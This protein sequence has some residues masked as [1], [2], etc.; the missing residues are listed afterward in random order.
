MSIWIK[1][2][3]FVRERLIKT[4]ACEGQT[5]SYKKAADILGINRHYVESWFRPKD[6]KS[7]NSDHLKLIAQKLG[8]SASWLLTGEGEPESQTERKPAQSS[9]IGEKAEYIVKSLA[10]FEA[11][12]P[13]KKLAMD[14]I[15]TLYDSIEHKD[16]W[17]I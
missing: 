13:Y 5:F 3:E 12:V 10:V 17:H 2:R 11:G 16:D 9:E 7:P 1:Q 8:I 15:N 14:S 4:L 6:I